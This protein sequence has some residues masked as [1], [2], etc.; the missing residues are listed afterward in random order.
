M[1]KPFQ[2]RGP[3]LSPPT[4]A[5]HEKKCQIKKCQVLHFDFIKYVTQM[6]RHLEREQNELLHNTLGFMAAVSADAED[7]LHQGKQCTAHAQMQL[8]Q[9]WMC[10]FS[11]QTNPSESENVW[12]FSSSH[13][14]SSG[15]THTINLKTE[16]D[17][18]I[19]TSKHI[20]KHPP[21]TALTS[22]F[23]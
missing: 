5:C 22:L 1:R 10:S 3:L 23:G 4:T 11:L 18:F 16:N 13:G 15:V 9:I 2:G 21:E 17:I 7:S 6:N 19:F 14:L 12:F 8:S 20:D